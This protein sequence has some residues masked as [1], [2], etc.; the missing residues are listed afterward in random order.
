MPKFDV[1]LEGFEVTGNASDA[2]LVG[3]VE[4]NSFAEAC[5]V[6]HSLHAEL[7]QIEVQT[8]LVMALTVR[9]GSLALRGTSLAPRLTFPQMVRHVAM[10]SGRSGPRG[11]RRTINTLPPGQKP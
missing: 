8:H 1:W 2:R 5:A 9:R 4:A 10:S 6:A 11:A 7:A 3:T